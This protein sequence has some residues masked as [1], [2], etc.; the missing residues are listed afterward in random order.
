MK[1]SVF[2]SSIAA[3]LI[4]TVAA[5]QGPLPA[6]QQ[7]ME[8]PVRER[9]RARL[10]QM[11]DETGMKPRRDIREE[12]GLSDVQKADIRKSV[13][14]A[15]RERLRKSTDLRIAQMDLRSLLRAEKVDEKAVTAKLAEVHAA[16]GALMKIRVDSVLSMKRI[17][18]PEQQK[19]VSEMRQGRGR[20]NARHRMQR[21][22]NQGGMGSGRRGL[23]GA[24]RAFDDDDESDEEDFDLLDLDEGR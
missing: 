22:L 1:R 23:R 20:E 17:L 21:G 15:R 19:K 16:Q 10:S 5:A 14:G 4:A 12:L 3:G 2:L 7:P 24:G 9:L 11:R 6:G 8:R 13:E 18:T